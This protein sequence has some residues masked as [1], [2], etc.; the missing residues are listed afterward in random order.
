MYVKLRA[1]DHRLFGFHDKVIGCNKLKDARRDGSG[2]I[3]IGHNITWISI[4]KDS[5]YY[6]NRKQ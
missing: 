6:G 1:S 3:I 2:L 4:N 5:I